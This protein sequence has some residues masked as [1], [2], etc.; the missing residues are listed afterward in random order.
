MITQASP[1]Q[2]VEFFMRLIPEGQ[3]TAIYHN[4]PVYEV[5]QIDTPNSEPNDKPTD[6]TS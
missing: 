5:E 3:L 4:V 6:A 2:I 1:E